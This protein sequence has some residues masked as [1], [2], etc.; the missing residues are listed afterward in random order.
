[1]PGTRR[2]RKNS[3]LERAKNEDIN[4]P[5]WLAHCKTRQ[6]IEY[7]TTRFPFRELYA[8]WLGVPSHEL[9]RFQTLSDLREATEPVHPKIAQAW[10]SACMSPKLKPSARVSNAFTQKKL[11]RSDQYKRLV[12]TYRLFV[13]EILAPICGG[14]EGGNLVYQCPPTTRVVLPNGRRTISPHSD[15]DYKDHQPAEINFWIPLTK[16]WGNNSLWLESLPGK[17]DYSPVELN[18]G[19]CLRFDGY[20]CRHYTVHNDTG[21]CR[22][23]FDF[24]VI[25]STLCLQ[26]RQLGEFCMEET[27]ETGL[28]AYPHPFWSLS[29]GIDN[30]E[31]AEPQHTTLSSLYESLSLTPPE[32][33]HGPAAIPKK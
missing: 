12:D 8:D 10:K 2:Q 5:G 18:Y 21:S 19:Q 24:R 11:F 17:G 31:D 27:T 28:V 23:S 6:I 14:P 16:V 25:P 3:A 9:D 4:L 15:K 20:L 29:R 33:A 22:V 13:R 32:N 1:M 7:D 30:L 26:R